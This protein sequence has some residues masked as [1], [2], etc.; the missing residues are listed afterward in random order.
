[1]HEFP[2]VQTILSCCK[3]TKR[4]AI[5][6]RGAEILEDCMQGPLFHD[7]CLGYVLTLTV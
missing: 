2:Q 3:A 5:R 1:M 4:S 7:L 6:L